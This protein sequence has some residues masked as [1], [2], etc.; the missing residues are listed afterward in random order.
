V[1]GRG[2]NPSLTSAAWPRAQR[3]SRNTA[4]GSYQRPAWGASSELEP[5]LSR[6]VLADRGSSSGTSS[7]ERRDPP[8]PLVCSKMRAGPRAA[9]FAPANSPPPSRT[10]GA[11]TH[12]ESGF[13]EPEGLL[14]RARQGPAPANPQ[15][16]VGARRPSSGTPRSEPLVRTYHSRQLRARRRWTA[17]DPQPLLTES[18]ARSHDPLLT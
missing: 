10:F 1:V 16:C 13:A 12:N 11:L 15:L 18:S 9:T 14:W 4:P 2:P 8:P 7:S 17:R 6:R 5:D 3:N